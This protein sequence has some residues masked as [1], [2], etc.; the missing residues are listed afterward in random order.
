MVAPLNMNDTR[1]LNEQAGVAAAVLDLATPDAALTFERRW[2]LYCGV[3]YCVGVGNAWD[4]LRLTL[5]A[6]RV[7]VGCEVLL[8][9]N[10]PLGAALAVDALGAVVAFVDV[11]ADTYNMDPAAV[12]AAVTPHTSAVVATHFA[13]FPVNT[14]ALKEAL[15]QG[16]FLV[17]LATQAHGALMRGCR[18][19]GLADAACFGFDAAG[20]GCL[21][22]LSDAGA[23]TTDSRALADS[24]R[25]LANLGRD[26]D[27][28]RQIVSRGC[29]SRMDAIN[30]AVLTLK[31]PLLDVWNMLRTRVAGWYMAELAGVSGVRVVQ[32]LCDLHGAIHVFGEFVVE[33]DGH[34]RDWLL[35]QLH[36]QGVATR[37]PFAVPCCR[38]SQFWRPPNLYPV[39]ERLAHCTLAL[40]MCPTMKQ[41]DVRRV[42]AALSAV[43]ITPPPFS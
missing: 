31:L 21:G 15:P 5:Q 8:P 25:A 6:V 1:A 23:V 2:A 22:A 19:G 39:A 28:G 11:D 32:P 13:G 38:Q 26:Y 30:A 43:L 37:A 17:E 40:P 27:A 42:C 12:C 36:Q 29:L 7:G 9:A 35:V 18:V 14:S 16:V 24:V 41:A 3:K 4:A 10:A 20:A 34:K 33:V